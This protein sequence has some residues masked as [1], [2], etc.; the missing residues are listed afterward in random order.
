MLCNHETNNLLFFHEDDENSLASGAFVYYT[1]E[2]KRY[3]GRKRRNIIPAQYNRK[4]KRLVLYTYYYSEYTRDEIPALLI[5]DLVIQLT[6]RD[7]NELG[8]DFSWDYMESD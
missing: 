5:D 6:A 4:T 8:Y 7:L 3:Y 1:R 2:G